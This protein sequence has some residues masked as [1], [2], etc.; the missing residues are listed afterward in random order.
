MVLVQS[1]EG[2]MSFAGDLNIWHNPV[3]VLIQA[4][5]QFRMATV[6]GEVMFTDLKG[7]HINVWK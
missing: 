1:F 3:L 6:V 2:K 5:E 7:F 4:G